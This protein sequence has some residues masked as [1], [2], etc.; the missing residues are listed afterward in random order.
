MICKYNTDYYN[1]IIIG[2]LYNSRV[3]CGDVQDTDIINI[4]LYYM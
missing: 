4:V 2:T 1:I 3:Q